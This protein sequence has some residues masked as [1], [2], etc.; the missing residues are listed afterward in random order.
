MKRNMLHFNANDN[1]IGFMNDTIH[2][3]FRAP[4]SERF[5]SRY[6]GALESG[7]QDGQLPTWILQEEKRRQKHKLTI[8]YY[9]LIQNLV[10]SGSSDKL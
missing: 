8:H 7:G 3:K 9:L 4:C 1:K 10:A 5:Q 6:K 2:T